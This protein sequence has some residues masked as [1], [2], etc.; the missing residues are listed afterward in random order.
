MVFKRVDN[1][2]GDELARRIN[3]MTT[4]GRGHDLDELATIEVPDFGNTEGDG[5]PRLWW[6]YGAAPKDA[7]HFYVR[8]DDWDGELPTPWQPCELYDG[9][10]GYKAHY[11]QM[12]LI[13][14]RSQPYRKVTVGEKTYR[15]YVEWPQRGSPWPVG[16]QIHTEYV[17]LADGLAGPVVF[18]F[19]GATG[20]AFEGKGG[21]VPTAAAALSKEAT[22]LYKRKIGLSA[23]WL[24][25]GPTLKP[26]GKGPLFVTL[27]Q[28][29]KLNYPA[30]HLP[31]LEGRAL[32]TSCYVGAS[33]LGE[34]AAIKAEYEE[35]SQ[36]RRGGEEQSAAYAVAAPSPAASGRNVPQEISD[37]DVL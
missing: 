5:L 7:G 24:P 11:L 37:D 18:S 1:S 25:V 3:A 33:V 31:K 16:M 23:F 4:N 13:T 27:P 26:D 35:W 8:G 12:V 19:H 6:K 14:K 9:E 22:K 21:I 20:Q 36:E 30:L 15:E 32:L 10:D 2:H 34:V 28:G 17:C 29:S